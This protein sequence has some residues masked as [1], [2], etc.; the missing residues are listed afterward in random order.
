[1]IIISKLDKL[2]QQIEN[3]EKRE[4]F[5]RNEGN[6]HKL[7]KTSE[8]KRKLILEKEELEKE[9]PLI[10]I[11][12]LEQDKKELKQ[13]IIDLTEKN[14]KLQAKL[15]ERDIRDK[16]YL[17]AVEEQSSEPEIEPDPEPEPEPE[18]FKCIHCNRE[19][20]T[21]RGLQVHQRTCRK[22]VG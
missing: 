5:A 13:E 17:K 22:S 10:T 20:P 1:M 2:N 12:N 14:K 15:N 7:R 21:K 18:M 16:A 8:M 4:E 11:R 19:F 3:L 9:A 6:M